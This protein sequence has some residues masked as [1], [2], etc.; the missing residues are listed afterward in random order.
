MKN[1][2][3]IR[4]ILSAGY[5]YFVYCSLTSC[6][7]TQ[8]TVDT[9]DLSYLYN[10]TKNPINPSY[11]VINQSDELSVLSVKFL[12][13]DLFFSEANPQGVPTALILI[14]VKLFNISQGK[15]L[16]D[17]AVFNINIIKE[18][19]KLEY[20]YGIPLKVEKGNEYHG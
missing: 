12:R 1:S 2:F 17:T 13:N 11:N 9:K 3:T 19:G 20:V 6:K 4:T 16:A 8:Q 14:T 18:T 5:L 10:P 7:T 15:L